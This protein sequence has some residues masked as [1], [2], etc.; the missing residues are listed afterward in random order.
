MIACGIIF[1]M[2][3]LFVGIVSSSDDTVA[4]KPNSVLELQ[5]QQP[6]S[7][8]VGDNALDPFAGGLSLR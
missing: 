7:D 6:I 4:V 8:Y 5:F 2:F 3:F 1:V